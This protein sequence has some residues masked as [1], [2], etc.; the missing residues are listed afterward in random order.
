MKSNN[1]FCRYCW[2]TCK[3]TKI[4][5][6]AQQCS[7]GKFM[8]VRPIK[9][10]WNVPDILCSVDRP[11]RYNYFKWPTWR[12]ILFSYMFIPNLYM[13]RAL[14][15]SSLGELIVSVRHLVY[16]TVCTWPSGVQVW[17]EPKPAYQTVTCIQWHTPDALIQLTLKSLN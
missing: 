10:T 1:E 16:V 9:R 13:F 8:S 14:V 4:L 6:V 17:V 7:Y 15:C 2:A 11:Y 12:T 5:S 3:N